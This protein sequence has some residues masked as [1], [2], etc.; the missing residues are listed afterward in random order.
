GPTGRPPGDVVGSGGPPRPP[1]RRQP[2]SRARSAETGTARR[3]RYGP[4]GLACGR[5]GCLP[6]TLSSDALCR[7]TRGGV[8]DVTIIGAGNMARGIGTRLAAAG[9]TVQI[10]DRTP[11]KARQL[12]ADLGANAGQLGADPVRG[13]VVVLAVPYTAVAEIAGQLA[14]RIVVD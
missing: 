6:D 12:A 11:D 4:D 2:R 14:G 13:D 9:A 10:L 1:A 3:V 5:A 8:M 7:H